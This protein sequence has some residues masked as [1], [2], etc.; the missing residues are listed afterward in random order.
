M[1]LTESVRGSRLY[2][3]GATLKSWG[4]ASVTVTLLTNERFQQLLVATALVVSV[5]LVLSSDLNAAIKFLSFVTLFV[6]VAVPLWSL[7]APLG[8]ESEID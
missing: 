5:V 6:V 3:V 8:G 2:R 4:K 7:A 1:K